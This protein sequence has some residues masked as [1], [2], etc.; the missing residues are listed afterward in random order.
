MTNDVFNT[1]CPDGFSTINVYLFVAKP[2]ELID[3]LKRS[4]YAEELNRTVNPDNGEIANCILK[5][6]DSS[7]MISQARAQ[8]MNMRTA[9]YLF[10]EEVDA[11]YE[12]ALLHGGQSEFPPADMD[13]QDRQ[14][15]IVDPAGN[16]WWIS[17]RLIKKN[18]QD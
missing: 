11:L 7:F 18:Y 8:F 14:A 5:I 1:Y 4:F 9:L 6:G 3:F 2:P 15:G 12:N 13:Y 10:T 17:K 16:Y